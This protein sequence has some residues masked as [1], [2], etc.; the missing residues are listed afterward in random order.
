VKREASCAPVGEGRSMPCSD[1]EWSCP[2]QVE[3]SSVELPE[4]IRILCCSEDVTAA[5]EALIA[6]ERQH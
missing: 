5:G 3:G 6:I 1:Q 2:N 4:W